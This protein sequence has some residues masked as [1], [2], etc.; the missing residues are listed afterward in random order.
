MR[1]LVEIG[2]VRV[3]TGTIV[4]ASTQ[5]IVAEGSASELHAGWKVGQTLLEIAGGIATTA[6][7]IVEAAQS[8]NPAVSVACTGALMRLYAEIGP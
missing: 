8:V 5:I 3:V 2:S 4:T 7:A 1:S 6:K